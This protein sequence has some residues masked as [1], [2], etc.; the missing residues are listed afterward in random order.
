M[1]ACLIQPD[2]LAARL[3]AEELAVFD[4][5]FQLSDPEAGERAYREAHI[6]GAYYLHLDRDLS[7]PKGPHGGRHPLPDWSR[8]AA[9]LSACGVR[10]HSTVVVYDAGE[11]MAARAWWLMRHIGLADVRMLDGGWKRWT[12]E[13]RP[14]TPVVPEP[15]PGGIEVRLR[16]G[17]IIEMEEVR[18]G[19]REGSL[20]LVDARSPERYRGDVEPIDPKAGHIPGALNH[21]WEQGLREDGT[22]R[23][24]EEQRARF[25]DLLE[26]AKPIAVYCGSGV[27]AC[28]TLFALELAGIPAKL[29]PGSW[30]DWVSYPDNPV[31]T[32]DEPGAWTP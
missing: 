6:P 4:C 7:S 19:A 26:Q 16:E 11:G 21:P 12:R 25:R 10:P 8:F 32:G 22:W 20:V 17:E 23:S 1:M 2:D 18:R 3:G 30:S 29:Y 5:R 31:A 9:R 28:S 24:P 15:R 27:T 13:K 14:V